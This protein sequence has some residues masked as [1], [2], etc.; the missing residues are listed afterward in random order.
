[1]SQGMGD[2]TGEA[3]R[4]EIPHTRGGDPRQDFERR[5]RNSRG[6]NCELFT[7]YIFL[8]SCGFAFYSP[9]HQAP[10]LKSWGQ[11]CVIYLRN[12]GIYYHLDGVRSVYSHI[13][14]VCLKYLLWIVA[15]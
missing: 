5:K 8:I 12:F 2:I 13:S 6:L 4:R 10:L 9:Y 7:G 3:K 11:N 15:D 14:N 1:M